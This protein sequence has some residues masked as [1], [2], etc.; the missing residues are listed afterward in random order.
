MSINPGKWVGT[1]PNHQTETN[2]EKDFLI[3]E[4]F[5]RVIFNRKNSK[6]K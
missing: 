2:I 3:L 5:I 6:D 1:L 4:V